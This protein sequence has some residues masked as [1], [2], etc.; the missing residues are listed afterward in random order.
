MV[1]L[2]AQLSSF[3]DWFPLIGTLLVVLAGLIGLSAVL[4][5]ESRR[6]HNAR[7]DEAL[8]GVMVAL[9]RRA[10]ALEAWSHGEHDS[11]RTAIR[12]RSMTDPP[13][14]VDLQTHLD[15]ACMTAPRK[16]RSTVHMLT[17][18]ST[19][20][21]HGR[22]DWQIVRSADLSRLTRKWRTRVIDRAEFVSRLDAIEVEVRAQ[23]RL[24]NR[25]DD[26][27]FATEQLTG[28]SKRPLL[29]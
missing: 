7:F 25:R 16:H 8:A 6:R 13:S 18:A 28:L 19:M 29:I 15:I 26:D 17:N 9:G 11:G 5:A 14:D 22:V 3:S 1:W 24:A 23:E 10:E 20:M 12:V 21:S 27:D 2:T 4:G